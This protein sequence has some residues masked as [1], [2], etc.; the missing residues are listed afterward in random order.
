MRSA[1]VRLRMSTS[2]TLVLG[3]FTS[4]AILG[5]HL[6]LGRDFRCGEKVAG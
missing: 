1:K 4:E 2:V 5:E 6:I 3:A